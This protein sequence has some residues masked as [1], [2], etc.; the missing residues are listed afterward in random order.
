M[1]NLILNA[2]EAMSGPSETPRELLIRT[3][4]DGSGGVLVAVQDSGPGL[5]PESLDRLFDAFYTTKPDGLG[6]GPSI[7][8]S[9]IEAQGGRVWAAPNL[10]RGAAFQFSL[11][12]QEEIPS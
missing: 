5:K 3:E 10:P 7:C 1:L 4:Q 2:V 6:M 8:R 9:I 12:R 11:P